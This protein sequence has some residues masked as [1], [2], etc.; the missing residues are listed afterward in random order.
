MLKALTGLGGAIPRTWLVN[1][2]QIVRRL[3]RASTGLFRE[4]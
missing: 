2:A 4:A 3:P 1:S